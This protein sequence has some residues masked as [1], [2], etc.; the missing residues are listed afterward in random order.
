MF[1]LLIFLRGCRPVWYVSEIVFIIS[2][3][4]HFHRHYWQK[5]MSGCYFPVSL[6]HGI[7][8]QIPSDIKSGLAFATSNIVLFT[9]FT[10]P[11]WL[12]LSHVCYSFRPLLL[13]MAGT[14]SDQRTFNLCRFL[15]MTEQRLHSTHFLHVKT[16]LLAFYWARAP[17]MIYMVFFLLWL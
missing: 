11:L 7:K 14:M 1:P 5:G 2:L 10:S 13:N 15:A 9:L 17:V 6:F 16:S 12:P 3:P 4:C 8:V